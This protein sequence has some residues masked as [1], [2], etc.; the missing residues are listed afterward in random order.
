MQLLL[1]GNIGFLLGKKFLYYVTNGY[2]ETCVKR[3]LILAVKD[4]LSCNRRAQQYE[5]SVRWSWNAVV[6]YSIAVLSL[7]EV[8]LSFAGPNVK[9]SPCL[10]EISL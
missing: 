10:Y 9:M 2:S 6:V 4:R 1:I 8:Q 7:P 5:N 3:S